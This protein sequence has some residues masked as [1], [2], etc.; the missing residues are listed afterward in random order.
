[1]LCQWQPLAGFSPVQAKCN[2]VGSAENLIK[3]MGSFPA[4]IYEKNGA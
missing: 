3:R 1:M 2:R 4:N